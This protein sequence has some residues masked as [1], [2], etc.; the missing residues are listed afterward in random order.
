MIVASR[1]ARWSLCAALLSAALSSVAVAGPAVETISTEE[2]ADLLARG[3]TVI[4]VR[5]PDE[6]RSTGVVADSRLITAYDADGQLLP[7]FADKVAATVGK[8]QPVALICR[9]GN[10][11]GRAATLL[12]TQLG[13]QHLYNV[14]GGMQS[15]LG[16]Q[17]PVMPCG[18]C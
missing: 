12:S 4:D 3:G 10:R 2:L 17:R 1:P 7:G 15:W 13:Y 8:D 14:A 5:R 6:W 9:S 11:S 16:E 18:R